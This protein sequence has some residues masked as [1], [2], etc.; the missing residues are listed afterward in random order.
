MMKEIDN[1][2]SIHS[3]EQS[4]TA[5]QGSLLPIDPRDH[6]AMNGSDPTNSSGSEMNMYWC[7]EDTEN[8]KSCL[9]LFRRAIE[10]RDLMARESLQQYFGN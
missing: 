2:S 5:Y 8:E 1:S 9:E 6:I 7:R 3:I 4:G 10:Q